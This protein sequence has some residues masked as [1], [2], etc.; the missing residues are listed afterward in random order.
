MLTSHASAAFVVGRRSR[1]DRRVLEPALSTWWST[2]RRLLEG[3]S[4]AAPPFS[5]RLRRPPP[6]V[7][8][9]AAP[10][11]AG[12]DLWRSLAALSEAGGG[13]WSSSAALGEPGGG[14]AA[15]GGP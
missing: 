7:S 8:R 10:G 12:G 2:F 11:K 9:L 6:C 15:L 3:G 4:A 1:F 5:L 13:R 14:S